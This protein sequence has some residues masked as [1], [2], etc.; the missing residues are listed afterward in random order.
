[1]VHAVAGW[2]FSSRIIDEGFTPNP[3]AVVVPNGEYELVE[4]TY[5]SPVGDFDAWH[6]PAS[7]D[8]WVI[9]VHGLNATPAE[10]EPLF[11][12]LQEAG[13]PQLAITY[14]N[15]E[16]QPD[17]PSGYFR[18]GS[19]EWE[20]ILGAVEY[21]RANG[22]RRIVL[23][24]Y[25]TGASHALSYVYR[26]NFDDTA[27]V[28][29]DSANIDVG[30]TIDHRGSLEE[31]AFGIPL[32]PTVTAV[33]KFAASLRIDINWKSLDY[34]DKASRSLRVPVL[35]IHGTEDES[36]PIGQSIDLAATQP[37]L[38]ELWQVE[39]AGHVE[40]F[41]TDYDGYISRVL[42]FLQSVD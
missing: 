21:A 42:A 9:H 6:L 10:P 13:Y 5:A 35:A 27:G 1:V 24:G 3:D 41:Q 4:V 17:D 33:A 7:G 14:R 26:N 23:A 25:S 18:Y 40:S 11:A 36:V 32:P 8:T 2:V 37:D 15:D 16:G 19:A 39:G 28:I 29:T 12:A 20:D 31:L 22:S 34:I 38:V 30:S